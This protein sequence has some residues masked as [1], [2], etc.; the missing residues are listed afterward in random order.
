MAKGA[1][2]GARAQAATAI[3]GA[4]LKAAVTWEA[5]DQFVGGVV[6]K[7]ELKAVASRLSDKEVK[8][9]AQTSV[10]EAYNL[11]RRDEAGKH[12]IARVYRQSVMD[13]NT[14]SACAD[15]HNK[16][17]SYDDP[18]WRNYD[19]PEDGRCEGKDRCRCLLVFVGE[20]G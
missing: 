13:E 8:L 19:P 6:D 7:D 9:I 3:L 18:E 20:E 15:L 14:C 16:E 5:L 10:S 2:L 4:R 1:F 17:W 11:G 12:K